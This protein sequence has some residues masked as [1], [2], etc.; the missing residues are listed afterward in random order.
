MLSRPCP[1]GSAADPY[2]TFQTDSVNYGAVGS[3]NKDDNG[4]RYNDE[5][6]V[7]GVANPFI[8]SVDSDTPNNHIIPFTLTMTAENGLDPA[9]ATTYTFTSKFSLVVQRGRELPSILD[10]D[11]AGTEGGNID[12][13]GQADGVITLDSS[14]LWIID[15]PVLVSKGTNVK[16][17]GGRTG[18]VLEL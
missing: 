18:P 14:A 5:L 17:T 10:G 4:I 7:T 2:V 16:I 6:E 9:D 12:T 1:R 15:K 3:F 11:A 13:D 8:F